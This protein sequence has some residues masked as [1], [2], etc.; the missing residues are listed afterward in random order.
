MESYLAAF[1]QHFWIL[2][3][4]SESF[5]TVHT[6]HLKV[7]LWAIAQIG[8]LCSPLLIRL[9][10]TASLLLK[11]KASLAASPKTYDCTMKWTACCTG[12]FGFLCCAKFLLSDEMHF[13]SS[14]PARHPPCHFPLQWHFDICNKGS[15][16]TSCAQGQLCAWVPPALHC[17]L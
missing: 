9:P 7:L 15:K 17:A 11:M 16:L 5:R 8:A 10:I 14:L 1:L 13:D 2:S 4:P 3:N 12:F 6:P